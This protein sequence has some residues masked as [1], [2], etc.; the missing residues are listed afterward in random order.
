[1]A[2]D[3][4]SPPPA[5]SPYKGFPV[6]PTGDQNVI[7]RDHLLERNRIPRPATA[8]NRAPAPYPEASAS[9]VTTPR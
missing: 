7:D 5:E 1:M 9:L 6:D 2:S 3:N 8:S 4:A